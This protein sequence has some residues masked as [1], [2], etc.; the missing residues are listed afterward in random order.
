MRNA[1][2]RLY[3][4]NDEDSDFVEQIQWTGIISVEKSRSE[5]VMKAN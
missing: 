3:L 4:L 5:M 2:R 1:R